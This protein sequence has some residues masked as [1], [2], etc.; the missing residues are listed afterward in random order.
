MRP[1]YIT[2]LAMKESDANMHL[3]T[4]ISYELPKPKNCLWFQIILVVV[5][6]AVM[7]LIC[8]ALR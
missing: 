1:I 7:A 2:G 3:S 5:W 6:G 4:N 8:N